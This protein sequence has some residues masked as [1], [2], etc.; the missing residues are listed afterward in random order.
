MQIFE[1]LMC[2]AKSKSEKTINDHVAECNPDYIRL[3]HKVQKMFCDLFYEMLFNRKGYWAVKT[4][5]KEKSLLDLLE[6]IK[7]LINE[8]YRILIKD[9]KKWVREAYR[10]GNEEFI[11]NAYDLIKTYLYWK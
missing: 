2:G 9:C 1:C 10:T 5:D 7:V 6:K 8:K 4:D 11:K 3:S